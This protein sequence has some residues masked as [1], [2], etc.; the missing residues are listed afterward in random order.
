MSQLSGLPATGSSASSWQEIRLHCVI[1]SRL[2]TEMLVQAETSDYSHD[3]LYYLNSEEIPLDLAESLQVRNH[4][5][6]GFCHGYSGSGP[7]Q[8]AL[9]ICLRLYTR[10]V[11]EAVYQKFK[12]MYIASLPEPDTEFDTV[13]KV[14]TNPLDNWK[15]APVHDWTHTEVGTNPAEEENDSIPRSDDIEQLQ[16]EY[17]EAYRMAVKLSNVS[18]ADNSLNQSIKFT[19]AGLHNQP[20][21]CYLRIVDDYQGKVLIIATDPGYLP[22]ND[23]LYGRREYGSSVTNAVELIATQVCKEYT[24]PFQKIDFVERYVRPASVH[25]KPWKFEESWDRVRFT[26]ESNHFANP[27]WRSI[28]PKEIAAMKKLLS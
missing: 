7:A 22:N 14:P 6:S 5:P 20:S 21:Y 18:R 3:R 9:A 25:R 1:R 12:Q 8:L 11:A 26:L 19:Y 10:P 24:I 17:D 27:K 4:S 2:V 23:D 16:Q 13:L 15:L 28:D